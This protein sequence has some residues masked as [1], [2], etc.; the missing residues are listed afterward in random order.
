MTENKSH[1]KYD[2]LLKQLYQAFAEIARNRDAKAFVYMTSM[3]HG[4]AEECFKL[5]DVAGDIL[6]NVDGPEV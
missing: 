3:I 2:P 4:A 6:L 5:M 1:H